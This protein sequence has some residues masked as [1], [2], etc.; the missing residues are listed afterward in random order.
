[1]DYLRREGVTDEDI[2]VWWNM[3]DEQQE[4]LISED[5]VYKTAIFKSLLDEKVNKEKALIKLKKYIPIYWSPTPGHLPTEDSPLPYE[6]KPRI[7]NYMNSSAKGLEKFKSDSEK[8]TSMNA[9][10]RSKIE[11]REI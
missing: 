3:P 6:L 4:Q 8:F 10:L 5:E 1:M 9:Y 7:N 11:K 2:K